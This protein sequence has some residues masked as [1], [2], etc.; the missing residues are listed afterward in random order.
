MNII[1]RIRRVLNLKR[2]IRD[3]ASLRF[4][5]VNVYV[6]GTYGL[7]VFK[8]VDSLAASATEFSRIARYI[9]EGRRLYRETAIKQSGKF[10]P[11]KFDSGEE[12]GSFLYALIMERKPR[13]V[14]C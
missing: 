2:R 12:L 5:G 11:I 8:D 13:C 9:P 3:L 10:S 6:M 1:S 7:K 14:V 4:K